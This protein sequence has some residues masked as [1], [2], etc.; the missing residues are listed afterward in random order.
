A[1]IIAVAIPFAT[2]Q[3]F[4][5][6]ERRHRNHAT[7]LGRY[8]LDALLGLAAVRTHGAERALRRGHESLLGDWQRSGLYLL[9]GDVVVYATQM[10]VGVAF[11][12]WLV[13][14]FV[15]R[16]GSSAA[17]LLLVYW[18]LSLSY[19]GRETADLIRQYPAYRNILESVFE[20]LDAPE[21]FD[22]V[23]PTM[24]AMA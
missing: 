3:I 10:L 20:L 17:A 8:S 16:G 23:R 15:S 19:L 7:A 18:V 4:V 2:L 22:L 13:F 1:A 12:L 24:P 6:G 21:D 9:Q 11:A 5:A 14:G